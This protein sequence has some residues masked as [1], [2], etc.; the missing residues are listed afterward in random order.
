VI[1]QF[2]AV[3]ALRAGSAYVREQLQAITAVRE[4]VQRALRPL[5]ADGVC[6]VPPAQ[7]AFYFLLRVH[8]QRTPLELAE[9]LIRQHRVAIIPGNAFG[10]ERGCHLR[11]AYGALQKETAAEGVGRLAEGLR[12]LR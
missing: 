6:E 1:S 10:L 8:S 9:Q 7:G 12:A 3:G 4:I 5:I 2:A 11:L